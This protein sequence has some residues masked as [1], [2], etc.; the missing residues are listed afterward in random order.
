[1]LAGWCDDALLGADVVVV[2][3]EIVGAAE[4]DGDCV[5]GDGGGP[6]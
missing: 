3:G 5:D 4:A 2:V 6:I 1:M